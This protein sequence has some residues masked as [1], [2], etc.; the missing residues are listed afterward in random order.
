LTTGGGE[1]LPLTFSSDFKV[2]QKNLDGSISP[3]EG[4]YRP[5]DV[6]LSGN[7]GWNVRPPTGRTLEF[8][9]D[10]AYV[11]F[12]IKSSIQYGMLNWTIAD[13]QIPI[14]QGKTPSFGVGF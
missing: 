4:N 5:L 3:I 8:K 6:G 9:G 1:F 12:F 10:D 7:F 11:Q 14:Y 2:Q 13:L